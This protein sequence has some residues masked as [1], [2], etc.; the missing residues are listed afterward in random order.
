[1][2]NIIN[3]ATEEKQDEILGYVKN[4]SAN[5]VRLNKK[6]FREGLFKTNKYASQELLEYLATE[7]FV[8]VLEKN[9]LIQL[10]PNTFKILNESRKLFYNVAPPKMTLHEGT[11]YV[12]S[13]DSG[14][15]NVT[16][17]LFNSITLDLLK[18]VV[19]QVTHSAFKDIFVTDNYVCISGNN[20]FYVFNKSDLTFK[21]ANTSYKYTVFLTVGDTLYGSK[22]DGTTNVLYKYDAQLDAGSGVYGD[23]YATICKMIYFNSFIYAFSTDGSIAKIL[24]ID[25]SS[26][27]IVSTY[28]SNIRLGEIKNSPTDGFYFFYYDLANTVNSLTI[29]KMSTSDYYFDLLYSTSLEDVDELDFNI[30]NAL[31]INENTL[32]Y[33]RGNKIIQLRNII[34][35]IGYESE[36]VWHV[37]SNP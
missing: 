17:R 18:E 19:V 26:S 16:F 3:L 10:D 20:G 11:L 36:E 25:P 8:Y 12:I 34:K 22:T 9:R 24:K 6:V 37:L 21:R 27:G 15:A 30:Q 2:A 23:G 32:Y 4:T 13:T 7:D 33:K 31:F 1:M 29:Y 28:S 35:H 5:G 14:Y